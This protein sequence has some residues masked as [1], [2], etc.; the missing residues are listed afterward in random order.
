MHLIG[1]RGLADL[2]EDDVALGI[3]DCDR[4]VIASNDPI[5]DVEDGAGDRRLV[6]AF[7]LARVYH[8]LELELVPY[9]VHNAGFSK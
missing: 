6:E 3:D 1:A 9:F 7:D 4:D 8:V 5:G 2:V